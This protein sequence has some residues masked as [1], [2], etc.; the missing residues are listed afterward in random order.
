MLIILTNSKYEFLKFFFLLKKPKSNNIN[1]KMK[2]H[3]C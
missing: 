1:T 3:S 2:L